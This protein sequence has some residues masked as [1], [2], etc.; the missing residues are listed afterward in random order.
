MLKWRI[1]NTCYVLL[2][3]SSLIGPLL[4]KLK[5]SR[6][7]C[8]KSK[9]LEKKNLVNS[10]CL[11][12]AGRDKLWDSYWRRIKCILVISPP[13][14]QEITLKT[15]NLT[16]PCGVKKV[17]ILKICHTFFIPQWCSSMQD[18]AIKSYDNRNK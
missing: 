9:D 8:R 3:M 14:S 2:N 12:R 15:H 16:L 4:K 1:R 6:A 10:Y 18:I 17:I 11:E 5:I 13:S 7:V